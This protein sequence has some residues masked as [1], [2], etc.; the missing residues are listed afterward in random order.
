MP[1]ARTLKHLLD[2]DRLAGDLLRHGEDLVVPE[3]ELDRLVIVSRTCTVDCTL[4]GVRVGCTLPG[5]RVGLD[6]P[7]A[8]PLQHQ[9]SALGLKRDPAVVIAP[10][11]RSRPAVVN[12]RHHLSL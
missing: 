4:P 7:D 10:A 11:A 1:R 8:S 12:R 3:V 2:G 6:G 9:L 5:V